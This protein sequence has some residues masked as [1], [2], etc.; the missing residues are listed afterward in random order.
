MDTV[1]RLLEREW[2]E[3]PSD[4]YNHGRLLRHL[5]RAGRLDPSSVALAAFLR[6]PGAME[7]Y[8]RDVRTHA[9]FHNGKI[10]RNLEPKDI[11]NG[12]LSWGKNASNVAL[13]AGIASMRDRIALSQEAKNFMGLIHDVASGKSS[14]GIITSA[15][16]TAYRNIEMSEYSFLPPLVTMLLFPTEMSFKQIHRFLHTL[17]VRCRE[18]YIM[19]D[20]KNGILTYTLGAWK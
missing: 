10:M 14:I 5:I 13:R 12:I 1:L 16:Y 18:D 11:I 8:D 4:S 19:S 15:E 17:R 2:M 3:E 9:F 6:H 7:C 20:I